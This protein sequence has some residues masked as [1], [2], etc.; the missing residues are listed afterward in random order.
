MSLYPSLAE[1]LKADAYRTG[2][3]DARYKASRS[4]GDWDHECRAQY[5]KGYNEG[6]EDRRNESTRW[7][8]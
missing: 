1:A 3:C 7:P 4:Y 8:A 6:L 2:R 5:D